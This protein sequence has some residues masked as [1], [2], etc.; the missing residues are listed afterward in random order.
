MDGIPV[1]MKEGGKMERLNRHTADG[2]QPGCDW[3][4]MRWA[5]QEANFVPTLT[6][7]ETLMLH[8]RLRLPRSRG[9]EYRTLIQDT[10]TSMGL[11]KAE[12]TQVGPI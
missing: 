1:K 5:G 3:W 7:G 10:L 4:K 2:R 6:V 9:H 8:A 12:H 11:L